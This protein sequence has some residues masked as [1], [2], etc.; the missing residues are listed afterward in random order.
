MKQ[1]FK[2]FIIL[3]ASFFC[4]KNLKAQEK[5]TFDKKPIRNNKVKLSVE[6]SLY[7]EINNTIYNTF[8]TPS[9][10]VNKTPVFTVFKVDIDW[11]GKVISIQ[12]SDSADST[13]V[14]AWLNKPK[15]HDDKATLER[16]AKAKS[17]TN[18]SLLIPV[19]YEP[20]YPQQKKVFSYDE[21]EAI[22]KFNK[23]NFTGK[24]IMFSPINIA[25]LLRGNM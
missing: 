5:F 12:F 17:L 16:Y 10:M 8:Y 11:E 7:S 13:F 22:M 25:V 14:K 20:N 18:I 6:D 19:I 9:Y 15:Y 2:I 4:V 21:L 24:S 1:L 3:A 23:Q